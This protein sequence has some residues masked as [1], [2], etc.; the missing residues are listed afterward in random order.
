VSATDYLNNILK[1]ETVDSGPAAPAR[2]IEAQV[3]RI[4]SGWGGELLVE[5][6]STGAF[7][8]GTANRSSTH[9]DFVAL[10]SPRTPYDEEEIYESLATSLSGLGYAPARRDVALG[11]AIGGINVDIV[12]AKLDTVAGGDLWLYRSRIGKAVK[13]SLAHHVELIRES[14]LAPEIRALKLWRDQRGLDFPSFYLE[15]AAL[16]VLKRQRSRLLADN[17]WAVLGFLEADF[18]TKGMLDPAN[19]NN[20]VSDE[21]TTAEKARIR[22]A[23]RL[24]RSGRPWNEIVV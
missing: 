5:V 1:R 12:P 18:V 17:F 7:E 6:H 2:M 20:L 11:I 21:L 23:A 4:C 10:L 22:A 3:E 24:S 16:W 19:Y 15:L 13:T 8:K 9:I 14:G